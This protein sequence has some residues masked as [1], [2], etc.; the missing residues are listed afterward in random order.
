MSERE[1]EF[2]DVTGDVNEPPGNI[3][4]REDPRFGMEGDVLVRE[5]SIIVAKDDFTR[6]HDPCNVPA[7][8][9]IGSS[10]PCN[11]APASSNGCKGTHNPSNIDELACAGDRNAPTGSFFRWKDTLFVPGGTGFLRS[12]TCVIATGNLRRGRTHPL[13]SDTWRTFGVTNGSGSRIFPL[14]P[15]LPWSPPQPRR[16]GPRG[17]GSER[18]RA[19]GPVAVIGYHTGR[20]V[21][22]RSGMP[23]EFTWDPIKAGANLRK[24]R[25]S[26]PEAT[27]AFGDPFSVTITDPDHSLAEQRYLLIGVSS[28][29]R[30]LVVSHTER[31]D[32]IRIISARRAT[33]DEQKAYE[34]QL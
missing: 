16:R 19:A 7:D 15:Q 33:R 20:V 21:R 14:P 3:F 10:G 22:T 6:A 9:M 2:I 31:P 13:G 8:D 4:R 23:L 24:H 28:R 27:T 17:S 12:R 26:F 11:V 32:T 29:S 18:K 30:L 1:G 5:G 34:E 25:V